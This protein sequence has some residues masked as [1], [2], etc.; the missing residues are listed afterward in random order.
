MK[1]DGM[2]RK[3]PRISIN[4]LAEYMI[5]KPGRQQTIIRAQKKPETP[6]I[7]RYTFASDAIIKYILNQQKASLNTA[8]EALKSLEANSDWT[9]QN[10]ELCQ[11]A[12]INFL[13]IAGD[14]SWGNLKP[15]KTDN[16][17]PKMLLN[18]V[19][20]SV[21]PEI[22]LI[23]SSNNEIVGGIKLYF[24]KNNPLTEISSNY[25]STILYRYLATILSNDVNVKRN[26]CFIIDI[27][28]QKIFTPPKAY[29]KTMNDVGAA[30]KFISIAWDAL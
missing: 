15:T 11:A 10:A 18:G 12:L 27:F 17:I 14:F 25:A 3:T 4:Q 23:D 2:N 1:R 20:I 16:N 22:A 26:N 30:C 19:E 29:K 21:R 28:G 13:A 8:I 7:A 9:K 6:I 5:A 24:N